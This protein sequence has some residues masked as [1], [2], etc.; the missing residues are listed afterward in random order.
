MAKSSRSSSKKANNRRKAAS[1]FGPAELARDE[2]LSAKLLELA[3]APK[4]E[5]SD[6]NMEANADDVALDGENDEADADDTAM[7]IDAKKP[8]K[9]RIGKKRID[10]RKQKKSKVVFTK[11]S[12]RLAAKKKGKGTTAE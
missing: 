5:S 3:K 9:A 6:V 1:V 2:R 11:Y 4:P 10:K 7:E 12:D 8:S